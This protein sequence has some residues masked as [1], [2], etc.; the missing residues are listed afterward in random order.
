MCVL[1]GER[2]L[3]NSARAN[4]GTAQRILAVERAT[5]MPFQDTRTMAQIIAK[6]GTPSPFRVAWVACPVCK[7]RVLVQDGDVDHHC[8]AHAVTGPWD[9]QHRDRPTGC[10]AQATL[11]DLETE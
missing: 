5:G 8:P 2:D 6:A 1:A 4:P 3:V 10:G 11:F 9:R 7:V